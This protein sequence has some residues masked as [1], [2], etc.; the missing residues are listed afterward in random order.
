MAKPGRKIGNF[1]KIVG[2]VTLSYIGFRGYQ[3][4]NNLFGS[5]EKKEI[6]IEQ[7]VRE[8]KIE[9][10]ARLN[11][12]EEK[13]Q[14]PKTNGFEQ[15]GIGQ[16]TLDESVSLHKGADFVKYERV[17]SFLGNCGFSKEE[18][19]AIFKGMASDKY[20]AKYNIMELLIDISTGDNNLS[21]RF[22][23]G[24]DSYDRTANMNSALQQIFKFDLVSG[25]EG[26]PK[27]DRNMKQTMALNLNL[28]PGNIENY[29]TQEFLDELDKV[30]RISRIKE[31]ILN[32]FVN[33]REGP[34][35]IR[36]R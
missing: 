23:I 1:L 5:K 6:P 7:R 2:L 3:L 21:K 11:E 19:L 35:V 26:K 9:E 24:E 12:I 17:E 36:E 22:F 10:T 27:L 28:N 30:N 29:V 13:E 31:V 8:K 4:I 16:A 32:E 25:T 15:D 18:T 20:S 34:A 33:S 14:R